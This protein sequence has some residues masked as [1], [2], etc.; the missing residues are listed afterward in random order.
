MKFEKKKINQLIQ[1]KGFRSKFSKNV[2]Q[3]IKNSQNTGNLRKLTCQNWLK[4]VK[5]N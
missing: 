1:V 4:P 5:V 3:M 2:T